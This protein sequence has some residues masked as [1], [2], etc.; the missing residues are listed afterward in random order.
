MEKVVSILEK[1]ISAEVNV[2]HDVEL[3]VLNSSSG[4]TRQC[5][6]VIVTGTGAR[7]TTTIVEVQKRKSKPDINTFNGWIGKLEEVGGQHLICVSEAGFP[8]SVLEKAR[9]IGPKVRLLTLTQLEAEAGR[10][11]PSRS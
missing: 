3:P 1:H 11:P 6:V 2:S 5:D 4:R 9:A 7:Q 8:K 10:L